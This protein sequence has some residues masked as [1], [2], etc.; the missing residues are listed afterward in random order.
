MNDLKS[1][2]K[3][4]PKNKLFVSCNLTLTRFI[5]INAYP[6]KNSALPTPN[7]HKTCIKHTFLTRKIMQKKYFYLPTYPMFFRP[8]Q[9]TNNFFFRPYAT[10]E[11]GSPSNRHRRDYGL[12][13]IKNIKN[14]KIFPTSIFRVSDSKMVQ[15]LAIDCWLSLTTA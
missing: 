4:R 10:L 2:W 13:P 12:G 15:D 7:Q 11:T 5:Q 1:I 14:N 3:N 6:P 9:E 8:L